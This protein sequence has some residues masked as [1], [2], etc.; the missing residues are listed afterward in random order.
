MARLAASS[1]SSS[2]FQAP[3]IRLLPGAASTAPP[4]AP[5][6]PPHLKPRAHTALSDAAYS[7]SHLSLL[8]T[9]R[10][11][12]SSMRISASCRPTRASYSGLP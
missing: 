3:A 6:P 11:I 8:V 4:P 2:R 9:H 10:R 12:T 7:R 5:E 1:S